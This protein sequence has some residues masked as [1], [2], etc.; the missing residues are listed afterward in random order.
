MPQ[1]LDHVEAYSQ[2]HSSKIPA[3]MLKIEKAKLTASHITPNFFIY[4]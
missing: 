2:L 1:K 3:R 4:S